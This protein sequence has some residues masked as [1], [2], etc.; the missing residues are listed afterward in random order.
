MVNEEDLISGS[1]RLLDVTAETV[2]PVNITV[3]LLITAADVIHS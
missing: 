2:L 3:R 1:W